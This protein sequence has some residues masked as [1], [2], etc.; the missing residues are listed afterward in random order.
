MHFTIVSHQVQQLIVNLTLYVHKGNEKLLIC[1]YNYDNC[2]AIV[3]IHSK[4]NDIYKILFFYP[5]NFATL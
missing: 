2:L 4:D 3:V 5:V 1:Y